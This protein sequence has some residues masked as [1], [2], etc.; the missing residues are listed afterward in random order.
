MQA[1]EPDGR[2]RVG[3]GLD[4]VAAAGR[5]VGRSAA[6]RFGFAVAHANRDR[7]RWHVGDHVV[8]PADPASAAVAEAAGLLDTG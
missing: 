4:D 2:R 3:A 6:T 7:L 1:A 5:P 8:P